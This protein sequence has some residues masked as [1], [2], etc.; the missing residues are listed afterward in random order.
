M[1]FSPR[2]E[3]FFPSLCVLTYIENIQYLQC[4]GDSFN[5]SVLRMCFGASFS[6]AAPQCFSASFRA[7]VFRACGA[8]VQCF[9]CAS[10]L[11]SFSCF[12][13]LSF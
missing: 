8:A 6:G 7:A 9:A 10:V 3:E 11:A 12:V 5:A 4:F 1:C 13:R 2:N